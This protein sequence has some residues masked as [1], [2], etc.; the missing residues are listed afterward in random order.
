MRDS[1]RGNKRTRTTKG[2]SKVEVRG[3]SERTTNE[4]GKGNQP[5]EGNDEIGE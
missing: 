1:G 4:T 3:D 2:E 5:I